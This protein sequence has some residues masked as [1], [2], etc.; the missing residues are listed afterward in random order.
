MMYQPHFE[1]SLV[2]LLIEYVDIFAWK[3]ADIVGVSGQ[4][5]EQKLNEGPVTKPIWHKKGGR[6]GERNKSINDEVDKLVN[7]GID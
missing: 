6:Y 5:T 2:N 3:P 7:A 1:K 4:V